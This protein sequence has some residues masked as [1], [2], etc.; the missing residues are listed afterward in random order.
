MPISP[1]VMRLCLM[2]C[3]V[4]V[5]L[6]AAFYLRRRRLPFSAY[7]GWGMLIL[8]VPLIGPFVVLLAAPGKRIPTT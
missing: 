6:V 5:A 3:L 8:L 7:L 2:A 4:G 1:D